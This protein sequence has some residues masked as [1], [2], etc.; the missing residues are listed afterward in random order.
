M[1]S[2]NMR[3]LPGAG[4]PSGIHKNADLHGSAKSSAK[5]LRIESLSASVW[6]GGIIPG[7]VGISWKAQ[8]SGLSGSGISTTTSVREWSEEEYQGLV[9]QHTYQPSK[10][11]GIFPH[12][13]H[14]S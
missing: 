14:P 4:V 7:Q 12:G 11:K 1:V 9:I 8:P 2:Q 5:P 13:K 3:L 6:S 10:Q